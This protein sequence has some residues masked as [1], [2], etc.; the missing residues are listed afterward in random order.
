MCLEWLM[1]YV[2][3]SASSTCFRLQRCVRS[4]TLVCIQVDDTVVANQIDVA[5]TSSPT[6]M[7]LTLLPTPAVIFAYNTFAPCATIVPLN[8]A[9]TY[10]CLIVAS[11]ALACPLAIHLKSQFSYL[12]R[13]T[14]IQTIQHYPCCCKV[15]VNFFQ[16]GVAFRRGHKNCF[17]ANHWTTMRY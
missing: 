1:C 5:L 7:A 12:L 15:L 16:L 3:V 8:R 13:T 14:R 17:K 11:A 10:I 9:T 2:F 6:S 4:F